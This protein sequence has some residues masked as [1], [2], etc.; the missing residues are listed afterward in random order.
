VR[1]LAAGVVLQLAAGLLT[2]GLHDGR[3]REVAAASLTQA[4]AVP[5]SPAVAPTSRAAAAAERA[6]QVER[7][8]EQ[9]AR[10]LRDRDRDAFLATVHPEATALR[11]RQAA[12]FDALEQVPLASWSYDLDSGRESP[13]D[14]RLDRRYGRGRWWAPAVA[15]RYALEGFDARPVVVE[16]HLTF[17]RDGDRWLLSSDDDFALQGRATR[18]A[19]WDLGPVVA[20]RAEGVLVLGRPDARPLLE[21]V[22]TLTAAAVPRV[23][24][25]WGRWGEDVAVLVPGSAREMATMLGG[26]ADLSQIAAV[27]TAELRGGADE[28][29]PTGDRVV[30]NPEAFGGLGQLGRRVVLTHEV[31]HVAT[32]RASGP[33][34]PDWLAEGFADYVGYRGVELPVEVPARALALEVRAGRQRRRQP[35]GADFDGRLPSALPTD[36][37]F[38]GS[39]PRLSQ[40]YA[41]SWLA[42]RMIAERHGLHGL[43]RLYRAVGAAR[44]TTSAQ[45]LEQALR[46]ELGTTTAR[47]TADWRADLQRQLG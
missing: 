12:A 13:P 1:L 6:R 24:R 28:Y 29:D 33:A 41:G 42:V 38:D 25:V 19:L 15:L 46:A 44:G 8:L 30:V 39:N 10:A 14:E 34:V 37:D 45:G 26:N 32:R 11:A 36:A 16:Q 7:L 3:Q 4:R 2:V 20:V 31:T 47:L 35:P 27:A 17:A 40:A 5:P 18:R 23:T 9:R 22:A 43:L 21:Q